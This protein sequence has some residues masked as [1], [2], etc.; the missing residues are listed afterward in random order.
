MIAALRNRRLASGMRHQ[1]VPRGGCRRRLRL[2]KS[3]I[4]TLTLDG[5]AVVRA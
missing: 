5:I 4:A 3:A 2:E 1:F